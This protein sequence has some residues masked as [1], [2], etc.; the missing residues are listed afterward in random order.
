[1]TRS[2]FIGAL[3]H[4]KL[5]PAEPL[6][7]DRRRARRCNGSRNPVGCEGPVPFVRRRLDALKGQGNRCS[8]DVGPT[9][10]GGQL[11]PKS[12]VDA[13]EQLRGLWNILGT[14]PSIYVAIFNNFQG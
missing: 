2:S 3:P 8:C 7:S 9:S 12:G 14:K 1:M 4:Q 6:A 11:C 10:D 5:R 13:L